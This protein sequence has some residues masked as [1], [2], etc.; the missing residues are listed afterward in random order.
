MRDRRD[1]DRLSGQID[2]VGRE[3]IDHR[4]ERATKLRFRHMLEAQIGAAGGTAAPGF[5]FF[6]DG[7]GRKI[8][9][10]NVSAIVAAI[11]RRVVLLEFL[12]LAVEQNATELIAERVPHDRVETDEARRQMADWEEL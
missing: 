2:A 11:G 9:R 12:Y 4:P 1:F 10:Q 3:R 6:E 8:P 7:I 5:D